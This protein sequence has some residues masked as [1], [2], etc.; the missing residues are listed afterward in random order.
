MKI[1]KKKHGLGATNVGD[2]GGFA[3]TVDDGDQALELLSEAIKAAGHEK[4]I[5]IGMDVAASEFFVEGSKNYDLHFKDEK[6]SKSVQHL[7]S[8]VLN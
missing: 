7:T 2:E 5:E 6:K 1:I 8:K 4:I 3:P